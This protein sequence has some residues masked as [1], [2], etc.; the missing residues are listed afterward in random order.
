MVLP[1]ADRPILR[2]YPEFADVPEDRLMQVYSL[3]EIATEK[4]V[5][6][7]DKATNGPRDLYDF[8]CLTSNEGIQLDHVT[9]AICQKL[10]FRGK[11]C[12]DLEAAILQEEAGLKVLWSRRLSYQ[13]PILPEFEEVFRAIHT[14]SSKTTV[15]ALWVPAGYRLSPDLKVSNDARLFA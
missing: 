7:V 11:A 10:N 8:W 13:M 15:I 2:G 14:S 4:T 6:L 3:E 12:K 9:D 5:A 1:L